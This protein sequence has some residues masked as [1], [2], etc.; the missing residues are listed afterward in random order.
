[1]D[2]ATQPTCR[3]TWKKEK[4]GEVLGGVATGVGVLNSIDLEVFQNK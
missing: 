1:M 4:F 3:V 2:T